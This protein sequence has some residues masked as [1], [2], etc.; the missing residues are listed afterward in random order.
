MGILAWRKHSN[1]SDIDEC[2]DNGH[3]CDEKAICTDNDGSYTCQ[4]ID[5]YSGNGDEGN[6]A[7]KTQHFRKASYSLAGRRICI[8][9]VSRR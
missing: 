5:G 9:C 7:S 4:C 6:C 3:T 1:F 8:L 2:I